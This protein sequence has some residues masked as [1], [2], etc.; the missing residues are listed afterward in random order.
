MAMTYQHSVMRRPVESRNAQQYILPKILD[1]FG[2]LLK[3]L[4]DK[5][6]CSTIIPNA[7]KV[8]NVNTV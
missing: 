8:K 7:C 6:D 3:K 1:S 5:I 2:R 4:S